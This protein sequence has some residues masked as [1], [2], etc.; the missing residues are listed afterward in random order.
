MHKYKIIIAGLIN[1][2]VCVDVS[3]IFPICSYK[4]EQCWYIN[5]IAV[6]I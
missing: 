5:V 1:N 4:T 2:V 6:I 3:I